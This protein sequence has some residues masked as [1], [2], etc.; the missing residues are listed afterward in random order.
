MAEINLKNILLGYHCE[1]INSQAYHNIRAFP[2]QEHKR[3][4]NLFLIDFFHFRNLNL[5]HNLNF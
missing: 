1:K 3:K 2:P 4:V 5:L